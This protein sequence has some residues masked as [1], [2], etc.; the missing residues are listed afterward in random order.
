MN[1]GLILESKLIWN[2]FNLEL[3]FG[4]KYCIIF[5][6]NLISLHTMEQHLN[7]KQ[8]LFKYKFEPVF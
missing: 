3:N 4:H 8:L 1:F 7:S 2:H 6:D 5:L